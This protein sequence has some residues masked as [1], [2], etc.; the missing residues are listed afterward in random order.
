MKIPQKRF[1][2]KWKKETCEKLKTKP[3]RRKKTIN[4]KFCIKKIV[5]YYIKQKLKK[6]ILKNKKKREIKKNVNRERKLINC[7][8]SKLKIIE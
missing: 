2:T 4:C 3:E 6:E 5:P 8:S 1:K 7:N